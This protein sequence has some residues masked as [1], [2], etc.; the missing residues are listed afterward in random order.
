[1]RP[2][3]TRWSNGNMERPISLACKACIGFAAGSLDSGPQPRPLW[4]W[5]QAMRSRAVGA[6]PIRQSPR[7]LPHLG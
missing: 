6:E 4:R 7:N 3:G 5:P 2:T 1:M